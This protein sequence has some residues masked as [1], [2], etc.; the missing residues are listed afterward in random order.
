MKRFLLFVSPIILGL[1]VFFT[2]LFFLSQN[3]NGNGALQVTAVPVSNVYLNGKLVGKT[4]LCKCEGKD[5][6][7][8]GTYSIKLVP[9][10]GDNLLPYE[11]N[12]T[13]TKG[14]LTAVDRTFGVG[15]LSS[16]SIITLIPL[17]DQKA[18]EL[19]T[20]SFPVGATVTLDG[21]A[22]GNTPLLLK[23][24]TPSDH[25]LLISK[26]GY[27]D[28]TVPIHTVPGYE[29]KAI[30]SLGILTPDA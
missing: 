12:V 4:P 23:S 15:E 18:V 9:L 2:A 20:D 3:A 21:N 25:D 14:I 13:I 17:T 6:I 16:G 28:K 5:M 24:L 29:L 10:A 26:Q 11:D 7:S 1:I 22:V 27:K 30:I 19:Y 8:S